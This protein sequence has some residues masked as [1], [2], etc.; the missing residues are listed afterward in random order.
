MNAFLRPSAPGGIPLP[1]LTLDTLCE[2][3]D[4][5]DLIKIDAEGAEEV[6]WRGMG[7]TVERNPDVTV[8]LEFNAARYAD[9]E[10][11]LREIQGHGFPLCHVDYDTHVK[12]LTPE[13]ILTERPGEDWMLWLHRAAR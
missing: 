2:S 7:E 12:P 13:R 8:L 10:A 9:P 11:F 5:V 3:L 1:T 6:I 4:R